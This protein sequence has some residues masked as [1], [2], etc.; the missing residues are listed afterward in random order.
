MRK[1]LTIATVLV[2]VI[3]LTG[4][5]SL[6]SA[7]V[8]VQMNVSIPFPFYVSDKTVLPAGEYTFVMK[9]SAGS[10]G[11]SVQIRNREGTY[12]IRILTTPGSSKALNEGRLQFNCYGNRSFLSQVEVQGFRAGFRTSK[13]ENE[14]RAKKGNGQ[15]KTLIAQN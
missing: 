13:L 7:V 14:L 10:T 2:G 3:V 4:L 8:P 12:S 15:E 1:Q 5:A 6:A 11:S 9:T